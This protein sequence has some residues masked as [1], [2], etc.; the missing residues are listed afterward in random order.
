MTLALCIRFH[1]IKGSTVL[2]SH[3]GWV[4]KPLTHS[5]SV[6][7]YSNHSKHLEP[8]IFQGFMCI[9]V[10]FSCVY[11]IYGSVCACVC[12]DRC[13]CMYVRVCAHAYVVYVHGSVHA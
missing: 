1:L 5:P 3:K 12:V 6:G 9:C 8:V 2:S 10:F 4:P 13:V 7:I 11:G